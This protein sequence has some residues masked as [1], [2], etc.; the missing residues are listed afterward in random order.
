MKLLLIHNRH[1]H[2]SGPETYLFNL[3]YQLENLG[4]TVDIF[5]L[6]YENNIGSKN[7]ISLPKP[8]GSRSHYSFQE[9]SLNF[10]EKLK[11]ISSLF[12]RNDVYVALKKL[13]NSNQYDGALV[14]QFW[15]KLSPAIFRALVEKNI[16]T[17]LRI[18]DFGLICGTNTLLK[19]NQHSEEC[20]N[21][22]FGC[23]KN[24]CVDDSY[25]KSLINTLAQ[26][27]F[28][29][30]YSS[31]INYLFTCKNTMSIFHDAGFRNN[32]FHLPTFYPEDFVQNES[33]SSNKI[34]YLGRVAEDK[35]LHKII[36]LFPDSNKIFLE[37]WGAG[38]PEYISEL[39][40]LA[41]QKKN[42]NINLMGEV[43]HAKIKNLF[44]ESMFSII[45]SQ[46][47]DNLPNSLIESLS[48]GVP[49]IA[50]NHG[51]FPEFVI[52]DEN[53][54]LYANYDN[55]QEI[56][57]E[58]L[59]LRD[60]KKISLSLQATKLAKKKFSSKMH[61]SKLLKIITSDPKYLNS[62]NDEI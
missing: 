35:G 48:N 44:S 47:H 22:K 46:W 31:N 20:I 52:N 27:N 54:Y 17:T 58:I 12:Y 5:S 61:L 1:Y 16:P 43:E 10:I 21:S 56:F 59:N 23:L 39:K 49:V 24:K 3:I 60:E 7:S 53:G 9:Q 25:L 51:C 33:C 26:L 37:I 45:P 18:S 14:L 50:P 62:L 40:N 2:V 32:T 30:K 15:G 28:F 38:S 57:Y 11:V 4:H 6:D 19:D 55:L 29:R 8:I 34:I 13:L 41:S 42:K 36:P